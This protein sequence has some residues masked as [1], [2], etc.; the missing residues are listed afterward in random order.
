MDVNNDRLDPGF[1]YMEVHGVDLQKWCK[2]YGVEPFDVPCADC[3]RLVSVNIPFMAGRGRRGLIAKRCQCGS[4]N[5]PMVFVGDDLS[6][7]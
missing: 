5:C 3:G 4:G 2:R 1:P 6:I 7:L